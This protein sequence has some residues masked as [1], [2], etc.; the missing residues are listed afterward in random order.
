MRQTGIVK[1][2]Q[3][4]RALSAEVEITRSSACGES[5]ASCGLCPGRNAV[6]EAENSIGAKCGDT[7]T[8]DMADKKIL[9]A[10]FMVYIA[11]LIMMVIGYF[12]GNAVFGNETAAVIS[13]FALLLMTFAV[14]ICADKKIK[15]RYTPRI[16]EIITHHGESGNE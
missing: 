1:K 14:L 16:T 5:C 12:A 13:G 7:V 3:S 10:A 11:P 8:I 9:G 15:R 4:S 6:V 2:V